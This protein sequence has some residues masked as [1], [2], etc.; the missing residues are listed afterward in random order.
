[1]DVIFAS[2]KWLLVFV[3]LDDTVIFSETPEEH[4]HDR[5]EVFSLLYNVG[6][7]FKLKNCE[8]FTKTIADSLFEKL[9]FLITGSK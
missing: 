3:Y 5:R 6:I 4:M 8:F 7:T 1:M 2:V 9:A